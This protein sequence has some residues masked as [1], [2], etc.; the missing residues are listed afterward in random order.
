M[1]RKTDAEIGRLVRKV[2]RPRRIYD[3]TDY[4][5]DMLESD[6]DFLDNNYKVATALIE[7]F[8]PPSRRKKRV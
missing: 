4:G 3:L 2:L 7:V 5:P 1:A 6:A 8:A